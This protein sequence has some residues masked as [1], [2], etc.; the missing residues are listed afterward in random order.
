MD[1]SKA[2]GIWICWDEE[3]VQLSRRGAGTVLDRTVVV[4]RSVKTKRALWS[5]KVTPKLIASAENYITQDHMQGLTNLRIET[6][7]KDVR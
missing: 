7:E 2:R 5:S 4:G 1:K 6:R 3:E